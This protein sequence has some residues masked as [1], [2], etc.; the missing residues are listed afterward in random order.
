MS[1]NAG[2]PLVNITSSGTG[3][4]TVRN[5]GSVLGGTGTLSAPVNVTTGTP[6]PG[7]NAGANGSAANVGK[8]TVG[9][10]TLASTATSVFDISSGTVYDQLVANG[11]IALGGSTLTLDVSTA[12]QT[13]TAGQV[14]DLFRVSTGTLSGMFSDFANGSTYTYGGETFRANYTTTDFTL[15][16]LT[17]VPEPATWLGGATLTLRRRRCCA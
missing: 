12:N 2:T 7:N 10:L 3:T 5:S 11:N 14:L 1:V 16:A 6:N 9:P 15:T 8:L 17:S 4:V 13:Y